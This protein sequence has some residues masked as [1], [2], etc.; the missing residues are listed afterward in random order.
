MK[1]QEKCKKKTL[2]TSPIRTHNLKHFEEIIQKWYSPVYSLTLSKVVNFLVIVT[3][4]RVVPFQSFFMAH[5]KNY[6]D[7]LDPSHAEKIQTPNFK[8]SKNG[9]G[10]FQ[11]SFHQMTNSNLRFTTI[12][13]CPKIMKNFMV[14]F[15][16]GWIQNPVL[17]VD[18]LKFEMS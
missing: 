18:W 6:K 12:S 3:S 7:P 17:R 5:D 15:Y 16:R 11:K 13:S 1:I 14:H 4:T 8:I 10:Y 2:K 9:T